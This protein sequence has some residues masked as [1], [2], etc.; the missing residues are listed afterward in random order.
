MTR[1]KRP[2]DALEDFMSWVN[3]RPNGGPSNAERI[4]G[5]LT[6]ICGLVAIACVLTMAAINIDQIEPALMNL[7]A[8]EPVK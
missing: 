5:W 1:D 2:D 7:R 8:P 3:D 4:M 6:L